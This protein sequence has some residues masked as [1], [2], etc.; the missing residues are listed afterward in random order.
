MD[1]EDWQKLEDGV[2][3]ARDWDRRRDKTV[4]EYEPESYL[5]LEWRLMDWV[6][7]WC[8]L[9]AGKEDRAG[10]A[11]ERILKVLAPK[12]G[13]PPRTGATHPLRTVPV[14]WGVEIRSRCTE[15]RRAVNPTGQ[16]NKNVPGA[17]VWGVR[18]G[19][20]GTSP[21]PSRGGQWGHHAGHATPNP[22]GVCCQP[23]VR[24]NEYCQCCSAFCRFW[25]AAW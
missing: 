19:L 25:L 8:R 10:P 14:I 5:E 9:G 23:G 2:G 3:F 20:G 13:C 24:Q 22:W 16:R 1:M 21:A 7:E 17:P 11:Y 6:A 4:K 18:I 12:N 15:R